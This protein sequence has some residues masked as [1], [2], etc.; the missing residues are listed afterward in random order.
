M[1]QTDAR[2]KTGTNY[3]VELGVSREIVDVESI[4]I[5]VIK[6]PDK[7][8]S[9]IAPITGIHLI[10]IGGEKFLDDIPV[11]FKDPQ[12]QQIGI[13]DQVLGAVQRIAMLIL[14]DIICFVISE[15]LA[16]KPQQPRIV[17]VVIHDHFP[18]AVVALETML[19][20]NRPPTVTS[21]ECVVIRFRN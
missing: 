11:F 9:T 21:L 6:F 20:L 8:G 4:A 15:E 13:L 3:L 19:I 12:N 18:A 17:R 5:G 14:E 7:I 2:P 1:I 10:S 16:K